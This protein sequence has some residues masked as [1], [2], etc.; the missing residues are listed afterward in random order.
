M[1]KKIIDLTHK[2]RQSSEFMDRQYHIWQSLRDTREIYIQELNA[3]IKEKCAE[4]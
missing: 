3:L 1:D 4:N 2:I